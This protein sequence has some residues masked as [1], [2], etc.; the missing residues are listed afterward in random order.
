MSSEA[1]LKGIV[2][3]IIQLISN[4]FNIVMS[5]LPIEETLKKFYS[6][7]LNEMELKFNMNFTRDPTRFATLRDF[8]VGNIKGLKKDIKDKLRKEITQGVVNLES[9][10][11]LTARVKK[12][13][14]FAKDR[15]KMIARTETNRALNMSHMDAARQSS[16]KLKKQWD[17]HLDGRTS[18]VCTDLD[19]KTIPLN[20]KFHWRGQVFDSPPAHVNCRSRVIFIQEGKV[21]A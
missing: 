13:T 9:P 1:Q 6:Q 2:D 19:K 3:E 4:K 10:T 18:Q 8:T 17:S 12:V 15:A 16:L 7:G 11:E 5:G 14:G 21:E 20:Q